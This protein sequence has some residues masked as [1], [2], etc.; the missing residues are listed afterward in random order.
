MKCIELFS[1]AG[2]LALGLDKAGF[3]H[4]AVVEWNASACAT[5]RANQKRDL[6]P[7]SEWPL[8]E[9][10]VRNFDYA[11]YAGK[12]ELVAGGPPCQPFSLGGKHKGYLDERD[13]FPQAV[14]ALREVRPKA[15]L[16][17]NVK[18]LTRQVFEQY[19][20]YIFLQFTFPNYCGKKQEE[21]LTHLSRLEKYATQEK[22]PDLQYHVSTRVL[23]AADY[24]VPQR[25]HRV[26]FVGFRNDLEMQWA[27]PEPTHSFQ[28]LMRDQWITGDYWERHEVSKKRRPPM[29]VEIKERF[30]FLQSQIEIS[31]IKPWRTVRDAISDLPDPM[32]KNS[33]HTYLNHVF[34]PGAKAYPGHTGSPLDLPAK[35]L[36]A[37]DHGVPG[38]EN[39]VVMDDKTVR[40][41]TVRESSRLQTFPDE[42][43]FDGA[44]SE[45][46]RQLGNAVPVELAQAVAR[47]IKHKLAGTESKNGK[48]RRNALQSTR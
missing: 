15:F 48:P 28:A 31:P 43:L 46:M 26:F 9:M 27:I 3:K 36:K 29:P 32:K 1:G 4:R 6:K 30:G 23:N 21:W 22:D 2:G 39:M 20:R 14:R 38:G 35:T 47:N 44:W 41:F 19:F 37:G 12:V 11:Q 18:G 45:S 17:E 5:I 33:K 7:V 42:Y 24:G 40:Y 8:H 25:R 16:F 10:D 34:M 13:M